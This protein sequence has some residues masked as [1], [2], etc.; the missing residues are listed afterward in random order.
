[1]NTRINVFCIVLLTALSSFAPQYIFSQKGKALQIDSWITNPDRSALFAK[2]C[3]SLFFSD[4]NKGGGA[5][6][7]IDKTQQLQGIDGFGF[8]LTGG[9]AG[10]IIKMSSDKRR[11]LL[12]EL[13]SDDADNAGISYIRPC[14]TPHHRSPQELEQECDLMESGCRSSERSAHRQRR[15]FNVP[16]S[17]YNRW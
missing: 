6:I 11:K 16:G 13:F 15:L 3:D 7:V 14:E 5:T 10:L 17:P 9:S 8:A 4:S 12:Q 2:Q 1:M